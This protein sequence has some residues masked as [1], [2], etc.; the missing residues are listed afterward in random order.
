MTEQKASEYRGRAEECFQLARRTKD[1]ELRR[2]YDH[3][4]HCYI[5]LAD[6]EAALMRDQAPRSRTGAQPTSQQPPSGDG[7]S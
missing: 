5:E 7:S 6:A 3:L 1:E 2:Q 4:G